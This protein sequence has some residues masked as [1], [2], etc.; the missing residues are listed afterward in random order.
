MAVQLR[1]RGIAIHDAARSRVQVLRG[2]QLA[3]RLPHDPGAI[4]APD[5]RDRLGHVFDR[6]LDGALVRMLNHAALVLVA[7]RPRH[8]HRLGGA[9]RHVDPAAA[10]AV[11][12]SLSQPASVPRV[13]ALHQGDK[14]RAVDDAA[15]DA[16]CA[17][18]SAEASQRPGACAGS[19]PGVR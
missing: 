3:C 15:L 5:R 8:R 6:L 7:E 14:V 19:P 13:P 12:A 1:V 10:A 16:S 17:S 4:P 18:V 11:C 2:D 9:E